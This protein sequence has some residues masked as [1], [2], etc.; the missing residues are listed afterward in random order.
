M[1]GLAFKPSGTTLADLEA[2]VELFAAC[3]PG[4]SKFSIDYLHWLYLDNP[5]GRVIGFDAFDGSRLAAHYALIPVEVEVKGHRAL[6]SWSLNTATHP[7]YQG[8]GLFT[9]LAEKTYEAAHDRG[10]IGVIGVANQN[11]THGFVKKL[12]FVLHGQLAIIVGFGEIRPADTEDSMRRIWT[13]PLLEWRLRNPSQVY[14]RARRRKNRS[15]IYTTA[16]P[17]SVPII[18]AYADNAVPPMRELPLL[19]LISTLQPRVMIAF[20]VD[21][22]GLGLPIPRRILPSPW[23]VIYRSL[24]GSAGEAP[25]LT[26][27]GIDLDTF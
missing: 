24:H 6:A 14:Y 20:G 3:F 2:Y 22:T 8:Q 1:A 18:L 5:S 15:A 12:G 26:I 25:R 16:G 10:C 17:T 27:L 13:P 7:N 21:F 4:A 9:K 11:S 23:N 19:P